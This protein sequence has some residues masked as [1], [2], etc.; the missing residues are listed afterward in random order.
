MGID[1]SYMDEKRLERLQKE[2]R[3]D[4]ERMYHDQKAG[5][6]VGDGHQLKRKFREIAK[7]LHPDLA[8][9]FDEQS[10]RLWL[11]VQQAYEHGDEAFLDVVLARLRLSGD[12]PDRQSCW[13]LA[14]AVQFYRGSLKSLR[15]TLTREK[16]SFA[17]KF[18]KLSDVEVSLLAR[19][20]RSELRENLEEAQWQAKRVDRDYRD[21]A[22]HRKKFDPETFRKEEWEALRRKKEQR[23]RMGEGHGDD[24]FFSSFFE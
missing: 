24:A 17:W 21:L 14:S 10:Q 2:F 12:T 11:D 19:E 15:K 16:K 18:S 8:E 1:T 23:R 22:K 6:S 7:Q 5:T 20:R 4:H 13:D 9:G 3:A